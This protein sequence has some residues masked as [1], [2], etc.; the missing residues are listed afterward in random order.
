MK[1]AQHIIFL[2]HFGAPA[3]AALG[4]GAGLLLGTGRF[5]TAI[6]ILSMGGGDHG[7]SLMVKVEHEKCRLLRCSCRGH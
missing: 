1:Y 7:R 5:Y 3:P 4:L 6:G 2:H